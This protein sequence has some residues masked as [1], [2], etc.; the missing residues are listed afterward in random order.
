MANLFSWSFL[1]DALTRSIRTFAQTL[2][3]VLG[4][5]ALSIWEV[6]WHSAF[7]VAAGS[8]FLSFLMAIDRM[9][10]NGTTTVVE[11]VIVEPVNVEPVAF[12]SAPQQPG[13][14]CG[15]SLR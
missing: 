1:Q 9:G 5:G 7:G 6:G 2:L 15:E 8:A 10:G 3:A 12:V 4:G 11:P 13:A 14:G